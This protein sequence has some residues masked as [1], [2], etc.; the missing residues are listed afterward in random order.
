MKQAIII[1]LFCVLGQLS[2]ATEKVKL[3][4]EPWRAIVFMEKASPSIRWQGDISVK[5]M[6]N[7][8]PEDSIMAEN[9]IKTL[10]GL[11]ETI[12]LSITKHDYGRLEIYFLDSLNTKIYESRLSINGND[13]FTW[14]YNSDNKT[15]E[16]SHC[17]LGLNYTIIPQDNKQHFI[18]NT[19]TFALFPKYLR[20]EYHYKSGKEVFKKPN[21]IFFGRTGVRGDNGEWIYNE[22]PFLDPQ[23]LFDQ[24]LIK[25]VYASNF[26][27]LLPQA[28]KQ[29]YLLPTWFSENSYFILFFPLVIALFIL[30]GLVALIYRKLR[31]NIK[32][33]LLLFNLISIISILMLGVIFSLYFFISSKLNDPSFFFVQIVDIIGSILVGLVVGLPALN[34]FRLI[35][36]V[37][38]R[39]AKKKLIKTLLL[40][41]STSLIPSTTLLTII[42]F[43]FKKDINEEGIRA[44]ILIFFGFVFIGIIRALI[45]FFI[46]KEKEIKIENE[47]KLAN[48]RELKT[49]AELNALHSRINP[50]FLYNSLN[51]IAGL[52]K[53][54]AE[55]TEHMALSLSKLFRYS[56]NKE[57]SDWSTFAE[58]MEMVNVYLDI[59]KVRFDDRLEFTIDLPNEL[60]TTKIPRFII[61]P[62]VENAIKHG[63][64]QLV[65]K[66]Q[67][68]VT[69]SKN[70][71]WMEIS[72]HDNGP[73]FPDEMAPGFGLQSIYDKLE[74]LYPNCFELHFVNSP[75]KQVLIKLK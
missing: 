73:L 23:T 42:Y 6:G 62:L 47:V 61:Q 16:I 75:Q 66:G 12:H 34:I 32:N 41:L 25:A 43:S 39:N 11:C 52:A 49:K 8:T 56:I 63:I 24:Q 58:E 14:T 3:P 71:S 31:V 15:K 13:K 64:S 4:E 1:L 18:T 20:S 21:S 48:L 60:K 54:D 45:S 65:T 59:E 46:L 28:K 50:H 70:A 57:Q 38:H 22:P 55:K 67:I 9:A 37:I 53:T 69:V 36:I 44:M 27:V 5:L 10:N 68:A 72:V 29:Y 35:E 7:Y 40:F 2:M 30:V 74:I 33:E 19:L 17:E 51:S 26:P